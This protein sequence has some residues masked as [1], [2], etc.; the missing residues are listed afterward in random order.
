MGQ[1][2]P[3]HMAENEAGSTKRNP[4]EPR[5]GGM[6]GGSPEAVAMIQVNTSRAWRGLGAARRKRV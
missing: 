1:S 4:G 6:G 3:N 2:R 5:G